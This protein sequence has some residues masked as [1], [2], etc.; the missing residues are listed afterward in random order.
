MEML[1]MNVIQIFNNDAVTLICSPTESY[2][3]TQP[4]S[5]HQL[6]TDKYPDANQDAD[7]IS[8]FEGFI[9][10]FTLTETKSVY[11]NYLGNQNAMYCLIGVCDP[12][13]PYFKFEASFNGCGV[14][15]TDTT[16][17][18][19]GRTCISTGTCKDGNMLIQCSCS[20]KSCQ[21]DAN[22]VCNCINITTNSFSPAG[23]Y[24][25]NGGIVA[26]K[27]DCLKCL[28]EL[29]CTECIADN[30]KLVDGEC[31]CQD[32]FYGAS[33]LT[34]NT[35]CI[36]CLSICKTCSNSNTCD[37]CTE[38]LV[39]QGT[40][41]GCNQG[42]FLDKTGQPE[43]CSPCSPQC[44][45]CEDIL[46]CTGCSDSLSVLLVDGSCACKSGY[47]ELSNSSSLSCI[48]C[49]N[50]CLTC[51]DAF[52]CLSCSDSNSKIVH[53]TCICADGF[54]EGF[55]DGSKICTKCGSGCRECTSAG[56]ISCADINAKINNGSCVCLDGYFG[57]SNC[58]KCPD[59]CSRCISKL[60]C[61]ECIQNSYLT[62]DGICLCSEGY[63]FSDQT[64]CT[65]LSFYANLTISQDLIISIWSND[66]LQQDL[67][68]RQIFVRLNN[69]KTDFELTKLEMDRF[70]IKISFSDWNK[71]NTF[72]LKF[73]QEIYSVSN[74]KLSTTTI[75]LKV[76][77]NS[78]QVKQVNFIKQVEYIRKLSSYGAMAGV[79]LALGTGILGLDLNSFFDFM[80]T[81][82]IFYSVLLYDLDLNLILKEFLY[83]IRIQKTVPK[84]FEYFLSPSKGE[85]P[86]S[87]LQAYGFSSN[88]II[89]NIE[90][91]IQ[92]FSLLAIILM[93]VLSI[94]KFKKISGLDSVL[95]TFRYSV[96][97]RFWL[98]S[99][100]EIIMSVTVGIELNYLRNSVQ[101]FDLIMCLFFIVK[102][103]RFMK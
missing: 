5:I 66:L 87:R 14:L 17:D 90:V 95:S 39:L 53:R 71:Q 56:C 96:F 50:E 77:L 97:L 73:M 51:L 44:S 81:A 47:Y 28:S 12:C 3:E 42:Y 24:A 30:S 32:G 36:Q 69:K 65:A 45:T 22:Q 62:D 25:I 82:E 54:F 13:N 19:Y 101:F 55:V 1:S 43:T 70:S 16:T 84:I 52:T 78:E 40:T 7:Y 92:T 67:D 34:S 79:S 93:L 74:V 58:T 31:F 100:L 76:N 48:K 88:L 59:I 61:L 18:S 57:E 91:Y 60:D 89:L 99:F 15:P 64:I 4:S 85:S 27:K 68:T 33:P 2:Q 29:D 35:S 37:S 41:C 10:Y 75:K 86:N 83:G 49:P 103:N 80:N 26:C 9:W 6:G 38:P 63:E 46:T 11:F 98:Q 21:M 102:I 8:G 20:S 72:L 23:C 94:R